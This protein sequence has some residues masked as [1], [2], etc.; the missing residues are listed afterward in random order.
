MRNRRYNSTLLLTNDHFY[1]V[2]SS[3]RAGQPSGY[4][5]WLRAGRSGGS[6]PGEGDIFRTC[7][8]RP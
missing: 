6:N 5:D 1:T 4:S 7:P 3:L 2:S 8:D